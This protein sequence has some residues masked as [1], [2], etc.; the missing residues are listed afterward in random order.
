MFD[1]SILPILEPFVVRPGDDQAGR[2]IY[3]IHVGPEQL[4]VFAHLTSDIF[5]YEELRYIDL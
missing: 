4:A 3:N 2:F 1:P 5:Y